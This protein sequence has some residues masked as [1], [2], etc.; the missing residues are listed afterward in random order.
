M[1][2]ILVIH[3]GNAFDKYEDY[4]SYLKGKELSLEKLGFRG[5][6]RSLDE[7]LGNAYQVLTPQMPNGQNARYAE[8]RIWFDKLIN[9]VEDGVVLV[10][11]S[12]G[13]IF[14][15]KYLS[16]NV[17]PKKVAAT[18]LVAAPYNTENQH[19]L[20]DFNITTDLSRFAEQGG[21]VFLYHSKDDQV[22]P[23]SN[24]LSYSD[25]LPNAIL[26]T[27]EDRQHFNQAEFPELVEDI[28]NISL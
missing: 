1:R 23:Y 13:A 12:L 19:P 25:V 24:M 15:S 8:W 22:V 21:K 11:H 16:E 5:W 4:I 20:V 3:G 14:L 7:R 6:S 26:R 18:F 17:C 10:G 2:Q 28:R 9:L 27:F